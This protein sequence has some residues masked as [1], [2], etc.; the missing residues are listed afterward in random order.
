MLSSLL[1]S[2]GLSE[3][4]LEQLM[5]V[6]VVAGDVSR[7]FGGD[8]IDR[9]NAVQCSGAFICSFCPTLRYEKVNL[10]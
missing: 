6:G 7:G 4:A 10:M 9:Y 1:A 3:Q 8:F 5:A 2:S